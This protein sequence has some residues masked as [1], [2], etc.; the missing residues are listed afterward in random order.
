M[1]HKMFSS[2]VSWAKQRSQRK[3]FCKRRKIKASFTTFPLYFFDYLGNRE[4]PQLMNSLENRLHNG[5]VD[6]ANT[7]MTFYEL[8]WSMIK[9]KGVEGEASSFISLGCKA[10]N[11]WFQKPR[12]LSSE[13]LR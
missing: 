2:L 10:D 3:L 12:K 1:S 11:V 7:T 5:K 4:S 6:S 9:E 13:A 8:F